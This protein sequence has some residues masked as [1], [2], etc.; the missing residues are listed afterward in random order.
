[1][2]E[3]FGELARLLQQLVAAAIDRGE[4][5]GMIAWIW[6]SKQRLTQDGSIMVVAEQL[7]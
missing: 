1:M 7:A 6:L 2:E 5:L 4:K 3:M